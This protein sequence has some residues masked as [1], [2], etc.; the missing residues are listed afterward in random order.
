MATEGK[1]KSKG[2]GGLTNKVWA[3]SF[4]GEVKSREGDQNLQIFF[5]RTDGQGGESAGH[6]IIQAVVPTTSKNYFTGTRTGRKERKRG[7]GGG[8][9]GRGGT[10]RMCRAVGLN[11]LL[12]E[13]EGKWHGGKVREESGGSFTPQKKGGLLK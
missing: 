5:A 10:R 8:K 6:S 7:G 13:K 3:R 11:G 9:G 1:G 4:W 2:G 12:E